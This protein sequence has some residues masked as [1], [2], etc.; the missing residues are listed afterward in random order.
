M[1][2]TSL[3]YLASSNRKTI[4]PISQVAVKNKRDK[5]SEMSSGNPPMRVSQWVAG[6]HSASSFLMFLG[7]FTANAVL[8]QCQEI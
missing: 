4:A 5:E 1:L 6:P 3:K 2:G 8:P 7:L